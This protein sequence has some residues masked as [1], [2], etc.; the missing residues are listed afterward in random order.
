MPR[1][2]FELGEV[3]EMRCLH[4]QDGQVVLDWLAGS[5]VASDYRM[6]GVRFETEVF[7]NTGHKIPDRTLWCTHGSP[8]LR[9]PARPTVAR[10]QAG[11]AH[12]AKAHD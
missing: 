9:R 5:V 8:N 2:K 4:E 7:A 3:V 12:E 6:L 10:G 11:L 1:T